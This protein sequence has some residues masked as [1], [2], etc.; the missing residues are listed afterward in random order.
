MD[1]RAPSCSCR[2]RLCTYFPMIATRGGPARCVRGPARAGVRAGS[3][4]HECG[5]SG[6]SQAAGFQARPPGGNRRLSFHPRITGT[7][8]ARRRPPA[9]PPRWSIAVVVTTAMFHRGGSG[10][11][12]AWRRIG[13][14][15][16][17]VAAG[18]PGVTGVSL[19]PGPGAGAGPARC[20]G[21]PARAGSLPHRAGCGGPGG[22][23][24]PG[25]PGLAGQP[26]P[27][28]RMRRPGYRGRAG[29][30]QPG[31]PGAPGGGIHSTR[32]TPLPHRAGC[33]WPEPG[34]SA[35]LEAMVTPGM[36]DTAARAPG[37]EEPDPYGFRA[38]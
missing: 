13:G 35:A 10:G 1:P 5:C 33:A 15:R 6:G 26:R 11:V 7:R 32:A 34:A 4:P 17:Q 24:R 8:P 21:G 31:A 38:G 3:L 19:V 14:R 20:D 27:V 30:R 28:S 25:R 12:R 9:P 36:P 22:G 23:R 37:I 18:V 29:R 2:C 16:A